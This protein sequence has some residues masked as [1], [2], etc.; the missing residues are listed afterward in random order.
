LT[1]ELTDVLCENIELGMPYSLACQ[2]VGI[3]YT[4]FSNWMKAG[5]EEGAKKQ[6]VECVRRV[7][8]SEA[9]CARRCLQHIR[10]KADSGSVFYDTW[11]LERRYPEHFGS[12]QHITSDNKNKNENENLNVNVESTEE[13]RAEIL[14]RLSPKSTP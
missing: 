6:F 1:D 10:D 9:E 8:A 3:G 14:S 13:I 4:A 11:L 5:E 2:A 7:R 12:R